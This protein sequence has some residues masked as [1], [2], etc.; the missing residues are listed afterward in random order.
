MI[1]RKQAYALVVYAE[2]IWYKE[3]HLTRL[4]IGSDFVRDFLCH[5]L[6]THLWPAQQRHLSQLKS[7]WKALQHLKTKSK[8]KNKDRVREH[9][10]TDDAALVSH[11]QAGL[12]HI[13]DH[14]ELWKS[15]WRQMPWEKHIST[16]TSIRIKEHQLYNVHKFTYPGMMF[17]DNNPCMKLH[18]CLVTFYSF[19]NVNIHF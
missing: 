9:L 7:W 2:G 12:Q 19:F 13:M 15:T 8:D 6:E 1:V 14:F 16:S 10:F 17:M 4:H 11:S 5:T 3:R 18:A